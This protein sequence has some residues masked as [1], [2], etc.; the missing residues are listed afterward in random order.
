MMWVYPTQ[1]W[2]VSTRFHSCSDCPAVASFFGTMVDSCLSPCVFD[3][4]YLSCHCAA[5]LFTKLFAMFVFFITL[6]IKFRLRPHHVNEALFPDRLSKC[7]QVWENL[8]SVCSWFSK[9][10]DFLFPFIGRAVDLLP[11]TEQRVTILS[12]LT[13]FLVCSQACNRGLITVNACWPLANSGAEPLVLLP[14]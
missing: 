8:F 14:D 7:V 12:G 13:L 3:A 10:R 1:S 4:L 11:G 5:S 2:P 6:S 9:G